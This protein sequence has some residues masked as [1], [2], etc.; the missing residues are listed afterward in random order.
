MFHSLLIAALAA[1]SLAAPQPRSLQ[2][3]SFKV[4]SPGRGLSPLQEIARTHRKFGWGIIVADQPVEVVTQTVIVT[5]AATGVISSPTA[6]DSSPVGD[7]S[8]LTRTSSGASSTSTSDPGTED[9]EVEAVPEDNES[10]YLSPVTVG[11]QKL[12]LNFDTGSADL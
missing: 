6:Y 12:N 4:A 3:R 11:G 9:G 5:I 10:E 1:T 8:T 7:N 2:K